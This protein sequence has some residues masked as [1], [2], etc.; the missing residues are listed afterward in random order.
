MIVALQFG[1][2]RRGERAKTGIDQSVVLEYAEVAQKVVALAE[3]CKPGEKLIKAG[4]SSSEELQIIQKGL[5]DMSAS[6]DITQSQP[7]SNSAV[8]NPAHADVR[9]K[10]SP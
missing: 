5:F 2:A 7:L 4:R 6:I 10:N 1:V 3:S 9:S 8:S